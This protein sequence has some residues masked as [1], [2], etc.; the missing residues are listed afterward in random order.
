[1]DYS[2]ERELFENS[3]HN[4][5]NMHYKLLKLCQGGKEEKVPTAATL[6]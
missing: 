4:Y 3:M 1:M 2:N 6:A 5:V